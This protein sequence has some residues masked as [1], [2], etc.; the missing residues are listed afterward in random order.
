MGKEDKPGSSLYNFLRY[1]IV[2]PLFLV[3]FTLATQVLVV[4]GNPNLMLDQALLW[5]F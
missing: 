1:Y 4:L 5:K 3:V 2:P